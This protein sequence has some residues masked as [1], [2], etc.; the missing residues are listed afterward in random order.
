MP[1]GIFIPGK[2]CHEHVA[3]SKN[4]KYQNMKKYQEMLQLNMFLKDLEKNI[5]IV[6][7]TV[8]KKFF[9]N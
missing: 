9:L 2:K 5:Y 7:Y 8:F 4:R 1:P 3:L 6:S